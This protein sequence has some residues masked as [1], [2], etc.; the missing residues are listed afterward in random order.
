MADLP[1]NAEMWLSAEQMAGMAN[2][3]VEKAR[4]ALRRA[5]EAGERWRKAELVV[6][7]VPGRGRSGGSWEVRGDALLSALGRQGPNSQQGPIAE[8]TTSAGFHS[9]PQQGPNALPNPLPHVGPNYPE[10][11]PNSVV[12]F[13]NSD[14][15]H[16][17]GHKAPGFGNGT[18]VPFMK[19]AKGG[20]MK[21]SP[22]AGVPAYMKTSDA[23]LA[24][25]AEPLTLAHGD[26]VTVEE[27]AQLAGMKPRQARNC[28]TSGQWQGFDFHVTA[29]AAKG[30]PGGEVR[31]VLL[32]DLPA[33]LFERAKAMVAETAIPTA[34]VVEVTEGATELRPR[35]ETDAATRVALWRLDLISEALRHP[36]RSTERGKAV[37]E[38][39]GRHRLPDG[40]AK[41][42]QARTLWL[43]L[44]NYESGGLNAIKP[45]E[46]ARGFRRVLV[47]RAWD[48]ACPLPNSMKIRVAEDLERYVRSLWASG[49]NGWRHVC[50]LATAKLVELS[51]QA[52]WSADDEAL[53]EHC[54]IPRRMA[55]T[56]RGMSLVALSENDAKAYFDRVLP[57]I[58]RSRHGLQP[59]DIVVGDVHHM[60]VLFTRPD[61]SVA[62][63]KMITWHDIATNRLYATLILLN[64]GEGVRRIHVAMSFASL[65][66]EWGLPKR[67]YLDNGSEY[68]WAEMLSGF[69]ELAGMA[70]DFE[71][72]MLEQDRDAAKAV[73]AVRVA[74]GRVIRARP[75]N[76]PAKPVEGQF[77][78]LEANYLSMLDGWIGG[79]RMNS[80]T[81]NVGKKPE[82]FPG[83]W[84]EFHEKF[85]TVL[86]YYHTTPQ[87]G[88]LD[89]KTPREA[90][91]AAIG[92]GWGKVDVSDQALLL[93]FAEE[94]T[95]TIDRGTLTWDGTTYEHDK[96]LPMPG[97]K[98]RV[99]VAPHDPRMAFVFDGDALLCTAVPT[100]AYGF[101]DRAGAKEQA[102]KATALRRVIAE[103][104]ADC[105]RLDL[106]DEAARHVRQAGANPEIPV[107]STIQL[108]PE[109]KAMAAEA[110]RIELQR[111]A[112]PVPQKRPLSQWVTDED[113]GDIT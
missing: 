59:M 52:G 5:G 108:S 99:R 15:S 61:G 47:T 8:L 85:A 102:R 62:T 24:E 39:V 72:S 26:A 67:L 90:L 60:D 55:E 65:C 96:L 33:P 82:P 45:V 53:K 37:L 78:N 20:Y 41:W 7:W 46:R 89:G 25:P 77:S 103:K 71:V 51:Q 38:A 112:L 101:M 64:K 48:A 95:R 91:G 70:V 12:E 28:F 30:G 29:R 110:N 84:A 113:E 11:G 68:S 22:T 81:K 35:M 4:R 107:A 58:R 57:R 18:V 2:I 73:A 43:W 105:D 54:S 1:A 10:Q 98:V 9:D 14:P 109:A 76:A 34:S 23:F 19:T 75:Y 93:S 69:A 49:T 56:F 74:A 27:F 106:V 92:S 3:S 36:R 17:A 94:D 40:S 44:A 50:Q 80:K 31:V 66:Q 87:R 86:A 79:N 104:K 21:N 63:P 42:V 97:R 111:T 16:K 88:W 6:R 13:G 100:E 83:T 32:P